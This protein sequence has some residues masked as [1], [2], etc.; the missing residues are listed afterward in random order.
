MVFVF[1]TSSFRVF[2]HYF[3]HRF[4][5]I[6][7]NINALVTE[8]RL[9]SVREV[10]NELNAGGNKPF[11]LDWIKINRKIFLTPTQ[12]EMVFVGEIFSI[13]HFQNLI[14]QKQRLKGTPV[15][16]PFIIACAKVKNG[17]V[18]TEETMKPNAA[19]IPNICE[20]F[21]IDCTNVEGFM[22]REKW[23]F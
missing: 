10:F 11:N 8:E 1:D 21:G 6:W 19:R 16:D 2:G 22:E 17:C 18:V 3:P 7:D 9:I 4:P 23:E 12:E 5:T 13:P 15:A 14:G 20:H